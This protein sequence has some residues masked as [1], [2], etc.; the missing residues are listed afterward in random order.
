M[1]TLDDLIARH[2]QQSTAAG[3][4][5]LDELIS[6]YEN[7]GDGWGGEALANVPAD[8]AD[9]GSALLKLPGRVYEGVKGAVQDPIGTNNRIVQSVIDYAKSGGGIHPMLSAEDAKQAQDAFAAQQQAQFIKH[10]VA[11]LLK[12]SN[13]INPGAPVGLFSKAAGLADKVVGRGVAG[14]L[15]GTGDRALELAG[16]A[17]E[18]GGTSFLQDLASPNANSVR[19]QGQAAVRNLRQNN[20]LAYQENAEPWKTD[21]TQYPDAFNVLSDATTAARTTLPSRGETALTQAPHNVL[22]DMETDILGHLAKNDMSAASLDELKQKLGMIRDAQQAGTHSM[23]VATAVYNALGDFLKE[24]VPNYAETM[25]GYGPMENQI[26]E[27]VRSLSLG[28]RA[29]RGTAVNKLLSGLRPDAAGGGLFAGR[30]QDLALLD[31]VDPNL[32]YRLAAMVLHPAF[33]R[34]F[35]GK[36]ATAENLGETIPKAIEWAGASGGTGALLLAPGLLKS[37]GLLGLLSPRLQASVRYGLGVAKRHASNYGITQNNIGLLTAGANALS[38][39]G[40]D[41]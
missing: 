34:G 38:P 10:P 5:N 37:F 32:K 29:N 2:E 39:Q 26:D 22:D 19:D 35:V 17:G 13:V 31:Q 15:G 41:Q 30:A 11:Q 3:S 33:P 12:I 6:Q 4:P 20:R 23:R 9:L 24:K 8:L 16:E 14:Y 18:K 25:T 7:P 28:D 21:P 36:M 27:A 40:D 1:S